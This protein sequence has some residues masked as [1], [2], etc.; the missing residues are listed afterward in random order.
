M[1]SN[2]YNLY[3]YRF[4]AILIYENRSGSNGLFGSTIIMAVGLDSCSSVL[5]SRGPMV[6]VAFWRGLVISPVRNE[7]P[8]Q[9]G[10]S[11][12]RLKWSYLQNSQNDLHWRHKMYWNWISILNYKWIG[13]YLICDCALIISKSNISWITIAEGLLL[14][15]WVLITIIYFFLS[16][17][18]D[19]LTRITRKIGSH[20]SMNISPGANHRELGKETAELKCEKGTVK[21][22]YLLQA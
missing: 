20:I 3:I 9:E 8:S 16:T 14:C 18:T 19:I 12:I 1:F 6:M 13:E 7:I 2:E 5:H 11:V 4:R 10:H 21:M 17:G 22:K 15:K